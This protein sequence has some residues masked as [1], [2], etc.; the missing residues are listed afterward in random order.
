MP[1]TGFC[2]SSTI[3]SEIFFAVLLLF[4][5]I[6]FFDDFVNALSSSGPPLSLPLPPHSPPHI[7]SVV[8]HTYM[9]ALN[10][11]YRYV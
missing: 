4:F 10:H 2:S 11:R 8:L 6:L 3:F 9:R 5:P 7:P 1:G